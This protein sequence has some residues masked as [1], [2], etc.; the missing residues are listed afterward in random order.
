MK[1]FFNGKTYTEKFFIIPTI[2]FAWY[3][4]NKILEFKIAFL[5]WAIK[6]GFNF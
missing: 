3:K 1:M 4:T 5:K 2:E 6:M